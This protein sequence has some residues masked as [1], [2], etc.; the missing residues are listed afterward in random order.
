MKVYLV[1]D[2]RRLAFNVFVFKT[3]EAVKIFIKETFTCEDDYSVE[4]K[5]VIE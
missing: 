3:T 1:I 2:E 4:V 5:E